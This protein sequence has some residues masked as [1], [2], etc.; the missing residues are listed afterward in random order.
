MTCTHGM[1][2]A[3]SCIECM[4]D[5]ALPPPPAPEPERRDTTAPRVLCRFDGVCSIC[6]NTM[7][8]LDYIV[9]TT[10]G[11]WVHEGCAA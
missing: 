11:R 9:L 1:P 3:A 7:G 6:D 8:G 10:R 5:G 4:D 2:T